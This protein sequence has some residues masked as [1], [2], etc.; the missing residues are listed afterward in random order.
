MPACFSPAVAAVLH[1]TRVC[2]PGAVLVV[3]RAVQRAKG[4]GQHEQAGAEQTPAS[5]MAAPLGGTV[6]RAVGA[7]PQ[8]APACPVCRCSHGASCPF[9]TLVARHSFTW[10]I[11]SVCVHTE[12]QLALLTLKHKTSK[13]KRA[14]Q[15]ANAVLLADAGPGV[16]NLWVLVALTGARTHV[17]SSTAAWAELK[18]EHCQHARLRGRPAVRPP[19]PSHWVSRGWSPCDRV[20]RPQPR[21]CVCRRRVPVRCAATPA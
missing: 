11:A 7:T 16:R 18:G 2:A 4:R 3:Q 8:G 9:A 14:I 15:V 1:C 12:A 21:A 19:P 10:T 6:L 5:A 13:R 20:P 17:A